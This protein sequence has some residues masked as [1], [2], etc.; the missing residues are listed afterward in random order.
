MLYNSHSKNNCP[1]LLNDNNNK[2][3]FNE[4]QFI[5]MCIYNEKILIER[6]MSQ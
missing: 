1:L 4:N 5:Q 3:I 2:K 6:K